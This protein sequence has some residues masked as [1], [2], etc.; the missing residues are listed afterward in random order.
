MSLPASRHS[1]RLDLKPTG[2]ELKPTGKSEFKCFSPA[3][4]GTT[5]RL[6]NKHNKHNKEAWRP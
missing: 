3:T 2:C 1:S 6:H 5:E 4:V